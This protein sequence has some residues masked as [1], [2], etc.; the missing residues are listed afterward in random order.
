MDTIF[1]NKYED[2]ILN[3]LGKGEVIVLTGHRRSGKSYILLNIK[4]KLSEN[5]NVIF[6]DMENPDNAAIKTYIELN[7]YLKTKI[8]SDKRNYILIDEVQVI[9]EFEKALRYYVKQP[10][11]DVVVTGSNAQMLSSEIATVFAGRY[12]QIHIH[13]LD[14]TEFLQFYNLENSDNNMS[15]YLK[16]GGLPFLKNLPLSDDRERNNYLESI[17]NTIIVKDIISRRQ[18]RNYEQT[19]NLIRFIADN[20]GKTFS[21]LSI[22]NQLKQNGGKVYA[23]T[24]DEYLQL[25]CN[26][27]IIDKVSRYDIKGKRIFE[28]QEKYYFEDLGIRNFLCADKRF[29]DI[30]KIIENVVYL[31][32]KSLGYNVY[33][34][35]LDGKEIDFVAKNGDNIIYVQVTKGIYSEETYNREYG[36]LKQ[37]KDNYP[38]YVVTLDPYT[39]LLNPDGIKTIKLIDFLQIL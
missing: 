17:Y 18:I 21:S 15:L 1:R 9:S 31:K 33:I 22:A 14:Y 2:R 5:G 16:W 8:N 24:V 19:E 11:V 12:L 23:N 26:S 27:Y 6:I 34:G 38:K 32:L 30:E 3:L 13:S 4:Q 36:N 37:I 39:S 20:C 28:H 25:F 7:D 35:S 29:L 10:N